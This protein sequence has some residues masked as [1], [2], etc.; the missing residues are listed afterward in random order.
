L[1][2]LRKINSFILA[3]GLIFLVFRYTIGLFSFFQNTL[4]I[5]VF[6]IVAIVLTA[7]IFNWK[8]KD[9]TTP[10]KGFGNMAG[11]GIHINN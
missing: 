6:I 3:A 2:K 8:K 10:N 5:V 4:S 7:T 11:D 9:N 1:N